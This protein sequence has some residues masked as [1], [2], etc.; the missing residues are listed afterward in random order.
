MRNQATLRGVENS[1]FIFTAAGSDVYLFL[2]TEQRIYRIFRQC[3][4]SGYKESAL[5]SIRG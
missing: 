4:A 5:P 3:R 2:S 1:D